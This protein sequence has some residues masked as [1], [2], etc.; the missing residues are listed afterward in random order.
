MK[1]IYILTDYNGIFESKN[2]AQPQCSGMDKKL[3]KEYFFN[4][5]FESI[6]INFSNVDFRKMNFKNQYVLYTSSEDVG[7]HY[8]DYIEDIVLGL[9]LQGA[10][11]IPE[12]KYLRANNNKVFME[13]LRDQM[14]FESVKNI[15]SYHFGTIEEFKNRIDLLDSKMVIKP[16][17]GAMGSGIMLSENKKDLINKCKKISRTKYLYQEM[18]EIGRSFK[19]RGY[20]KKSKYRN[21]FIVQNFIPELNNDWKIV[22]YDKKYYILY[23]GIRNNDFRASGSGKLIFKENIPDGILD[24]AQEIFNYFNVPNLS[25]DV[26]FNGNH[27]YLLEFQAVYFGKKTIEKSSFFFQ[28]NDNKWEI[29]KENSGLEKEY[30]GSIMQYIQKKEVD[31]LCI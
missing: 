13:I 30:V 2:K 11:L 19:Y 1:K 23:R 28:K 25:I 24:F 15:K 10:I 31:K 22:I 20:L 6:F 27:F 4:N 18:W 26:A 8:K 5:G 3:L 12:Y 29:I 17:A 14:N 21:K 9:H 16:A 7:Y